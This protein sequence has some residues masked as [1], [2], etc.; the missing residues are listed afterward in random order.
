MK[1]LFPLI[2]LL[3]I[4]FSSCESSKPNY[5]ILSF[6]FYE[7][8]PYLM[9]KNGVDSVYLVIKKTNSW[10]EKGD[11]LYDCKVQ[12]N[13]FEEIF[14]SFMGGSS[15]HRFDSLGLPSYEFIR[16]CIASKIYYRWDTAEDLIISECINIDSPHVDSIFFRVRD[17]KVFEITHLAYSAYHRRDIEFDSING[18]I[19]KQNFYFKDVLDVV[20]HYSWEN[21]TLIRIVTSR[22]GKSEHV[23]YSAL[24]LPITKVEMTI[25]GDTM[26]EAEYIYYPNTP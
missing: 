21:D 16:S 15:I 3:G 12:K 18:E 9:N 7:N 1:A 23:Y 10:R 17:N 26:Y 2:V 5:E 24:G 20:K 8:I 22:D 14:Y 13:G 6:Y 11:T 19:T 4:L 25:N